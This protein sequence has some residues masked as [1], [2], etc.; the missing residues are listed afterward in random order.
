MAKEGSRAYPLEPS[1]FLKRERVDD[2]G[3]TSK[4]HL[5]IECAECPP[6]IH[7]FEFEWATTPWCSN[8]DGSDRSLM[9]I[10]ENRLGS[11][12][13]SMVLSIALPHPPPPLLDQGSRVKIPWLD[14]QLRSSCEDFEG[15]VMIVILTSVGEAI[16]WTDPKS[17][18]LR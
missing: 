16:G 13:G 10:T 14:Y 5:Y 3:G 11:A 7:H 9:H 2:L 4:H 8:D 15:S 12:T 1:L 6:L 18:E 17:T